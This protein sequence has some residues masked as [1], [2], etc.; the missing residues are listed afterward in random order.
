MNYSSSEILLFISAIGTMLVN[1]IVAWRTSNKVDQNLMKTAVIEGHVN[2]EKSALN[3]QLVS[4]DREIKILRDTITERD[5]IASLLAQSVASRI[6]PTT[7][8]KVKD[9]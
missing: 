8:E 2:S 4:K 6:P 7:I 5:R 3:E 1:V 9:K